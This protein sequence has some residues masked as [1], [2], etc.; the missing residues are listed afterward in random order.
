MKLSE[1]KELHD[2]L[3]KDIAI[4]P[5]GFPNCMTEEHRDQFVKSLQAIGA[6]KKII[7]QMEKPDR[8]KEVF[9]ETGELKGPGKA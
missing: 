3:E 5:H 2:R 9:P 6:L 8:F 1:Y 7:V 4:V